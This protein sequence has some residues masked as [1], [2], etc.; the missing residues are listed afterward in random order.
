[1]QLDL[2]QTELPPIGIHPGVFVDCLMGAT[3]I[4]NRTYPTLALVI[5]IDR[6]KSDGTRFTVQ[7]NYTL[8]TRGQRKLRAEHLLV[9]RPD[10]FSGLFVQADNVRDRDGQATP[11]L[12]GEEL[13]GA[14]QNRIVNATFLVAGQVSIEVPVSC[15]EA[16]RWH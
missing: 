12:A 7:R 15:V 6:A 5:E 1:M 8:N 16:G 14:K 3:V 2:T 10:L 4:K 11:I 13:V 9:G